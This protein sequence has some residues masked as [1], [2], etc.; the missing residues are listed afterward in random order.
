MQLGVKH[1]GPGHTNRCGRSQGSRRWQ[2]GTSGHRMWALTIITKH[3]MKLCLGKWWIRVRIFPLVQVP[4][5]RIAR[6]FLLMIWASLC[7]KGFYHKLHS[8]SNLVRMLFAEGSPGRAFLYVCFQS[9]C[10]YLELSQKTCV[11]LL[12]LFFCKLAQERERSRA[13]VCPSLP[14][15]VAASS[16]KS[17]GNVALGFWDK[18]SNIWKPLASAWKVWFL[19]TIDVVWPCQTIKWAPENGSSNWCW[20]TSCRLRLWAASASSGSSWKLILSV[21]CL[22]PS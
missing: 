17:Y 15:L 14:A 11:G 21:L 8:L 7:N 19:Y 1:L 18:K 4:G 3:L 5:A 2:A 6:Y 13:A 12:L 22:F 10:C 20:C 16:P 9:L